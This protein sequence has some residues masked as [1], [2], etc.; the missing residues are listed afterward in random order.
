[1]NHIFDLSMLLG[2]NLY[3][4][5]KLCMTKNCI[6]KLPSV[7]IHLPSQLCNFTGSTHVDDIK[8]RLNLF[9]SILFHSFSTLNFILEELLLS[10]ETWNSN[11]VKFVALIF[12]TL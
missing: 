3:L 2:F 10:N 8:C 9:L 12:V 4:T 6:L 7:V 11:T 5:F 1:M